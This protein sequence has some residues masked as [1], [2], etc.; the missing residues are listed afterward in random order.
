MEKNSIFAVSLDKFNT[1][2][3]HEF[4]AKYYSR[5]GK[6]NRTN[7]RGAIMKT[8]SLLYSD[9][10]TFSNKKMGEYASKNA[11]TDEQ[12]AQ[13][14]K[15]FDRFLNALNALAEDSDY[16]AIKN[17]SIKSTHFPYVSYVINK[18]IEDGKTISLVANWLK[19][20][21]LDDSEAC[22]E[23]RKMAQNGTAKPKSIKQS[24]ELILS[25]Y[26]DF[27]NNS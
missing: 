26:N 20:F 22:I 11:L 18:S 19:A 25:H 13:L 9:Y 21:V 3:N 15:I 7:K 6:A 23:Y 8:W 4:F 10:P 24:K 27:V 17:F 5:G 12:Y 2:T 14:T 1:L 16:A